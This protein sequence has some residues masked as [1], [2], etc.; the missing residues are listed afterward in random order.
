MSAWYTPI[1]VQLSRAHMLTNYLIQIWTTVYK[2]GLTVWT[3]H[4]ALT[5]LQNFKSLEGQLAQ[6]L[7]TLQDYQFNIVHRPGAGT[8]MQTRCHHYHAENHICLPNFCDIR[9]KLHWW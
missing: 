1:K 3:D 4:A 2:C 9:L 5:W 8:I 6:W 7:E